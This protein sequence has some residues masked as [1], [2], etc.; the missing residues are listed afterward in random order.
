ML[1]GIYTVTCRKISGYTI[2]FCLL[3]KKTAAIYGSWGVK[4]AVFALFN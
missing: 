2:L 3:L 1:A 4:I